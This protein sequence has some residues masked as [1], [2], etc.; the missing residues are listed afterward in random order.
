MLQCQLAKICT[1]KN[2]STCQSTC[3]YSGYME[4]LQRSKCLSRC[5][6]S[7]YGFHT[8]ANT[9]FHLCNTCEVR[10]GVAPCHSITK[11]KSCKVCSGIIWKIHIILYSRKCPT[12]RRPG[13]NCVVKQLRFWLFKVDCEFKDCDLRVLRIGHTCV[14]YTLRS[15]NC[16]LREKSQFAIFKL[17]N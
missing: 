11:L 12:Y 3:V 2:L 7:H 8:A 9:L 5:I 10:G 1:C 14:I 13:F 4:L 17:R 15:N 6:S 16:E